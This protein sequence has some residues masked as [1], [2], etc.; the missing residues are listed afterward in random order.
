MTTALVKTARDLDAARARI[1]ELEAERDRLAILAR[2]GEQLQKLYSHLVKRVSDQYGITI[3]AEWGQRVV[4]GEH[5]VPIPES[6]I[7]AENALLRKALADLKERNE[8]LE[9]KMERALVAVAHFT[10]RYNEDLKAI[11]ENALL[12]KALADLLEDRL[13]IK[14]AVNAKAALAR[15]PEA[16]P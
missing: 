10:H 2:H 1:A 16:K 9:A 15:I 11:A 6:D 4:N 7:C 12:R 8:T 5:D 13:S 3:D 14:A